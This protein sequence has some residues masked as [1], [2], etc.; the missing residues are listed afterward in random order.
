M[1]N[2]LDLKVNSS[3][4]SNKVKQPTTDIKQFPNLVLELPSCYAEEMLRHRWE[5]MCGS[6]HIAKSKAATNTLSSQLR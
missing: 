3:E 1:T 2:N 5:P 4:E 6:Q